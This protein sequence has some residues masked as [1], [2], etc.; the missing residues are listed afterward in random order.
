MMDS[1][2]NI[3]P[4]HHDAPTNQPSQSR[5]DNPMR[6]G[7]VPQQAREKVNQA[8]NA[9][10]DGYEQAKQVMSNAYDKTTET[11]SGSYDQA[12]QYGRANPGKVT[13][14]AFGAGIGVGIL[15]ASAMSSRPTRTSRIIQPVVGALTEIAYEV[16]R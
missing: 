7:A 12:M 3:S 16:F 8:A 5:I 2:S 14:I 9:V 6:A 1:R 13:A 10:Q 11:L 15:L 4:E